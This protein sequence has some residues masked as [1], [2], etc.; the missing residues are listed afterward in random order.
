[1][2]EWWLDG[3]NKHENMNT[4]GRVDFY[5]SHDSLSLYYFRPAIKSPLNN[6][7][8]GKNISQRKKKKHNSSSSFFF[9]FY[10][11]IKSNV[12]HYTLARSHKYTN[13]I[14]DEQRN[15]WYTFPFKEQFQKQSAEENLVNYRGV[16]IKR[17]KRMKKKIEL[18]RL[19]RTRNESDKI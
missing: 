3:Q 14:R 4:F 11:Q 16:N 8:L 1:M 10:Y 6:F 7:V 2:G 18:I 9:F 13:N 19:F 15:T 17:K 5:L 12:L